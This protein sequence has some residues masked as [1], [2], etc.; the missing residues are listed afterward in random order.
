M[1]TA[2]ARLAVFG[3]MPR[4][5]FSPQRNW[6]NDPNG[7][8]FHEGRYHLYYQY[9]PNGCDHGYMSWGHASSAD[10][11]TWDEHPVALRYDDER[12]VYSGSIVWDE[13]G[14]AGFGPALLAFY[15][16]HA[17]N[18]R[19][20]AQAIA[21]SHDGGYTW[22]DY[23]GNPVLDR[24]SG[25]FRDPK[26]LRY[27]GEAGE[28]WVLAAVEAVQQRVVFY[29]SDDLREWSLL[30][31]FAA[32]EVGEGIWECPD[33]FPLVVDG[34]E[35][36][37]LIISLGMA[38]V[39]GGF[40]SIYFVG[41][42]D[43]TTFVPDGGS[44]QLDYGRDNYAGVTFFGLPDEQRTLIGW[45]CNWIYGRELPVI[46]EEPRRGTMTL[47]RRLSL[48]SVDGRVALRQTP[49]APEV[50]TV[51]DAREP[52]G[53]APT[54]LPLS[55]PEC[56]LV[57][58]TLDLGDAT[59]ARVR[60]RHD[61][62]GYGGVVLGYDRGTGEVTLDRSA[63]GPQFPDSFRAMQMMPTSGGSLIQL[64]LWAD[65]NSVEIFADDGLATLSSVVD[66]AAGDGVTV[67][68]VGGQVVASVTVA[69]PVA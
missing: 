58:I 23:E 46:P 38:P 45:M 59:G 66:V 43:G 61:A 55:V 65:V 53:A 3:G 41:S 69:V 34:V 6:M 31:E 67:E 17:P 49:I 2:P 12:E 30:S 57:E 32:P 56:A 47:A 44:T 40:G 16:A 64:T 36:W 29:R 48:A 21:Y 11:V 52:V 62:D 22:T 42:F 8:V 1:T 19:H 27:R 54:R 39:V 24:Q 18:R 14:V 15:T 33:L 13:N 51:A 37:V 28:Y 60:L 9:N 4:I 50:E 10:L 35:K 25:D 20:Q 7:L 26:V 5:H 63:V 68:G